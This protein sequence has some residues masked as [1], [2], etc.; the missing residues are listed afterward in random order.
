M[1]SASSGWRK[2]ADSELTANRH[3]AKSIPMSARGPSWAS[4]TP[5]SAPGRALA[6]N[7]TIWRATS[8]RQDAL[9][10]G[11]LSECAR[12]TSGS[13][14]G[15]SASPKVAWS[16][17][18]GVA[19]LTT[20]TAFV[21]AASTSAYAAR[22]GAALWR[23]R[24]SKIVDRPPS[25][26][27]DRHSRAVNSRRTARRNSSTPSRP[28]PDGTIV[29]ELRTSMDRFGVPNSFRETAMTQKIKLRAATSAICIERIKQIEAAGGRAGGRH[30]RNRC[31]SEGAGLHYQDHAS[32]GAAQ[33]ARE[34][35][36][37]G[38]GSWILDLY[39]Q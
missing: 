15:L 25:A 26:R 23:H 6:Q 5:K 37:P 16:S 21:L 39:M 24:S 17:K 32:G 35:R 18:T 3:P 20:T 14:A 33:E 38:A 29:L 1:L 27:R 11:A 19:I 31:G 2:S 8:E 28:E 12:T 10:D 30:P 36:P 34:R 22:T 13:C 9:L 4:R 7:P